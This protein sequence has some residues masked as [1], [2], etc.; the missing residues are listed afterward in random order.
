LK[1]PALGSYPGEVNRNAF[2]SE[3]ADHRLKRRRCACR[4]K[5]GC[6][7][8]EVCAKALLKTIAVAQGDYHDERCESGDDPKYRD[9]DQPRTRGS[10][11]AHGENR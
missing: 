8:C 10:V 7:R 2:G 4:A 1:G 5:R 9:G 11:A 3:R 6:P